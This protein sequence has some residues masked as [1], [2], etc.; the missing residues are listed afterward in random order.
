MNLDKTLSSKF[1]ISDLNQL[2]KISN[3]S[4]FWVENWIFYL[5]SVTSN[6]FSNVFMITKL[7]TFFYS[8][9][10]SIS[11]RLEYSKLEVH[12]PNKPSIVHEVQDGCYWAMKMSWHLKGCRAELWQT[13]SKVHAGNYVQRLN[14]WQQILL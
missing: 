6:R 8:I 2:F 4:F 10:Y 1:H 7:L 13:T 12:G 11:S 9:F 3:I 14:T 5:F